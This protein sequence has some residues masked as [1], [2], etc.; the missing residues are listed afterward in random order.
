VGDGGGA[1]SY[2]VI[3]KQY[4]YV[5]VLGPVHSVKNLQKVR[6]ECTGGVGGGCTTQIILMMD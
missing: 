5:I 6:T 1:K 2:N 3:N 4:Y